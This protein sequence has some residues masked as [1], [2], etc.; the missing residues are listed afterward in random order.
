[1]G[2]SNE[3]RGE[4]GEVTAELLEALVDATLAGEAGACNDLMRILTPLIQQCVIRVLSHRLMGGLRACT[5]EEIED[6][7]QDT[8]LHLIDDGHA[9]LRQ[10][11]RARGA[12]S[13]YVAT[14]TRNLVVTSLRTKKRNPRSNDPLP[15]DPVA[16][17]GRDDEFEA[18]VEAEDY[19]RAV[20]ARLRQLLSA[21]GLTVL[22]LTMDGLSIEEI[23]KIAGMTR[24]AVNS[25]HS[26][27]RKL[28]VAVHAILALRPRVGP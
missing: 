11:D 20:A 18:R 9:V 25:H 24:G 7:V 5:P 28:A 6:F 16:F 15:E 1:M 19:E 14:V 21:R 22:K 23:A 26:R 4:T 3:Q 27:M 8:C 13:P 17:E 10:W 2:P 12:L